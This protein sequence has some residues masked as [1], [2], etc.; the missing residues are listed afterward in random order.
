MASHPRVQQQPAREVGEH[1]ESSR[2]AGQA[3]CTGRGRR[4][5]ADPGAHRRD[6]QDHQYEHLR[7]GPAPLPD[8]RG[9]HGRWRH[10]G[11]R[12]DGHRRGGRV[13]NRRSAGRRPGRHPVPDLLRALLHVRPDALHP[14]RDDAGARS[15]HRRRTLRVLRALRPGARRAGR[16]PTGAAGAVHAHQSS[17]GALRRTLRLPVRRAADGVAVRAL[18]GRARRRVGHRSWPRATPSG[19]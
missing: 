13:R 1:H 3:R 15:G 6:H 10:P 9:I 14:V 7:V 8:A 11:P 18:R 19:T 16:V 4:G 17:G 2:V 5:P 12:A